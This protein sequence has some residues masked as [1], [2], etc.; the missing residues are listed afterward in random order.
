[1]GRLEMLSQKLVNQQTMPSTKPIS[2]ASPYRCSNTNRICD[3]SVIAIVVGILIYFDSNPPHHKQCIPGLDPSSECSKHSNF[4]SPLLDY[5]ENESTVSFVTMNIICPIVWFCIFTINAFI[6]HCYDSLS[7][8]QKYKIALIKFEILFRS[9]A[10]SITLTSLTTDVIKNSVGRPRPNYLNN[11]DQNGDGSKSFPSGHTSY[12]FSVLFLLSLYLFQTLM[13]VQNIFYNDDVCAMQ[14]SK[15]EISLLEDNNENKEEQLIDDK[16][17]ESERHQ[18][19]MKNILNVYNGDSY[20]FLSL[21]V[22]LRHCQI[23]SLLIAITPT[24]CAVY[25]GC[26]RLTDYKHHYSDVLGGALIGIGFATMAF[27]YCRKEFYYGFKYD[28]N[29]ICV[30]V[31]E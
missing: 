31:K 23:V 18:I 11:K 12:I 20:L 25:V 1:M 8:N 22:W 21:F 17:N 16:S 15:D 3:W 7:I 24:L 30:A 14:G 6:L 13:S 28:L 10:I 29:R 2:F 4:P 27:V 19:E 5:P 26:S 9:I